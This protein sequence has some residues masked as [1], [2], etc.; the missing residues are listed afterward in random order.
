M[1]ATR[2]DRIAMIGV[3]IWLAV[4]AVFTAVFWNSSLGT[5][6]FAAFGWFCSVIFFA[7]R[8]VANLFGPVFLYETVRVGRRKLTFILR[9]LYLL[10]LTAVLG[11]V[12]LSWLESI[13]AV[14]WR[15]TGGGIR[16]GQMAKYGEMALLTFAPI[17]YF[18][19]VLLTPAYVAGII[20]DEKE[21]KTLE[22]LFAT[23]LR[24]R[25]IIFGKL[26]ARLLTLLMYIIA[27]LPLLASLMLF[28]GIDPEML[29]GVFAGTILTMIALAAVSIF[30]STIFKRPRDAIVVSYLMIGA[31][32]IATAFL[33]VF[34][35][36]LPL[37]LRGPVMLGPWEIPVAEIGAWVGAINPFYLISAWGG[38]G[39]SLDALAFRFAVTCVVITL[40]CMVRSTFILRRV[41]LAQSYGAV[42]IA[43]EKR[44]REHVACGNDPM[45]WK[46]VFV[47]SGR[48]RGMGRWFAGFVLIAIVFAWPVLIFGFSYFDQN[49][50]FTGWT[51]NNYSRFAEAMSIWVRIATGG[52]SFLIMLGAAT[53]AASTI[54][55]EKDRDTW[56][57]LVSTPL[58][59]WSIL[60]GKWWGAVLGVRLLVYLLVAVWISGVLVGSTIAVML[61]PAAI[62]LAIYT[63]FFG[64]LGVFVSCTA[65]TTLIASIRVM[66]VGLFLTGGYWIVALF[67]CFLP[68]G[69]MNVKGDEI[70]LF[71]VSLLSFWPPFVMGWLPLEKFT[72]MDPFTF[73]RR[74]HIGP[75]VILFSELIWCA[76]S[77]LFAYLSYTSFQ[78]QTNRNS[79]D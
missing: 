1:T 29:L 77:M 48:I 57:T 23:D 14:P 2:D 79:V 16:P 46:E 62:Q 64:W 26:A 35:V 66:M 73:N 20:A 52:L 53:R 9:T 65:R 4:G 36:A 67:C 30:F 40:Y 74:P 11:I 27:G 31:Y 25:E 24:N 55:S 60:L 54:T 38:M 8:A 39:L 51:P 7:P 17:Q 47:E 59:T 34:L 75:S 13:G 72:E 44:A 68:L 50:N 3:S 19:I 56:I 70:E 61:I 21:R 76:G 12:F 45:F 41:A 32:Y 69:I 63:A 10:M 58:E 43:K 49:Y 71:G 37:M 18:V 22:F 33:S 15:F 6:I 28:G 42:S 5:Q 78:R